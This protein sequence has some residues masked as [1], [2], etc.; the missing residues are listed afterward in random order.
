M[1]G[2]Y[3][4]FR[5]IINIHQLL[6]SSITF[7]K[8]FHFGCP[9]TFFPRATR[10]DAW[11]KDLARKTLMSF[12]GDLSWRNLRGWEQTLNWWGCSLQRIY[13]IPTEW[14]LHG[15]D[16]EPVDLDF[17][18]KSIRDKLRLLICPAP[19]ISGY[20]ADRVESWFVGSPPRV[21]EKD[22]KIWSCINPFAQLL[23]FKTAAHVFRAQSRDGVEGWWGDGYLTVHIWPH[24][25]GDVSGDIQLLLWNTIWCLRVD[26]VFEQKMK[27]RYLA[28]QTVLNSVQGW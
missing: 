10:L 11:D 28:K 9:I 22:G 24:I 16:D 25:L 27:P 20:D 4:S 19:E 5:C 7:I 13:G 8:P 18:P 26:M 23:R 1:D 3:Q 21:Y 12:G 17:S 15:A 2:S 6:D 14:P